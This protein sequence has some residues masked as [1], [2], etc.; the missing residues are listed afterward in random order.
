MEVTRVITETFIYPLFYQDSP[1]EIKI[2][3]SRESWPKW[4]HKK[5]SHKLQYIKLNL[6]Y[7]F[8]QRS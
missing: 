6:T 1:I 5:V 3:S 2:S 8:T 7:N 4:Q